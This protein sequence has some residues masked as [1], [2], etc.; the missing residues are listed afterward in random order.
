MLL[1][2]TFQSHILFHSLI[3]FVDSFPSITM[4]RRKKNA[5][6]LMHADTWTHKRERVC[7]RI[8][9]LL[10]G[11][12]FHL[13][14]Y[15]AQRTN[16]PVIF[17]PLLDD[18]STW[19]MIPLFILSIYL[20]FSPTH[21]HTLSLFFRK[22]SIEAWHFSAFQSEMSLLLWSIYK[23]S[24]LIQDSHFTHALTIE[25][26][27]HCCFELFNT[28]SWATWKKNSC[29][30]TLD[31]TKHIGIFHISN[32]IMQL[33]QCYSNSMLINLIALPLFY[34]VRV[35]CVRFFFNFI[36]THFHT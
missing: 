35:F 19:K 14:Y 29:L 24:L 30:A 32:Y 13:I 22:A 1:K 4:A 16:E 6:I 17:S 23:Y 8:D 11:F 7:A 33:M 25:A 28:S 27:M 36:C 34:G 9:T 10:R 20:L 18:I 15:F 12:P 2:K 3:D 31:D 21:T 26:D 5:H